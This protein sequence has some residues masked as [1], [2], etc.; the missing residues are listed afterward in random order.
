[1]FWET[2][3]PKNS[4][5]RPCGETLNTNLVEE[6]AFNL[7]K[8]AAVRL[9][10]DIK[11]ALRRAYDSEESEVGKA[12]LEAIFKNIELAEENQVPICQDTG[13]I[14]FYINVGA[15]FKRLCNVEAALVHA[16]RRATRQV[17]LRPNAVNPI[18]C[19]NSGDNTGRFLPQIVWEV[20]SGDFLEL[21]VMLKGGGSE[22]VSA[23]SM[24]LPSEGVRELKKFVVEAVVRAGAQPCPPVIL[25][26]AFG[27]NAD[28][29][30]KL[31]KKALLRPLGK[32]NSNPDLARLEAELLD[33]VN[34]TGIGPMGLG[35]RIT[36]LGVHVD[37]AYRHPATFPAAVAFSCWALRRASARINKDGSVE[38]LTHEDCGL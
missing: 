10:G 17:P 35:G 23:L 6:T 36:A 19:R 15:D 4:R 28:L 3:K 16:V 26:V 22:N 14:T 11:K 37:Y 31:A 25:G 21:T 8:Q 27:G 13:T 18:N 1:M 20:V 5:N 38:Y 33:A 30:M 32:A 34:S 29:V 12:Q 24:L 7:L 2:F 9:P